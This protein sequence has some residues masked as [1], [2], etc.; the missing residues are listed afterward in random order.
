MTYE[1]DQP[2]YKLL[3]LIFTVLLIAGNQL[4]LR[5]DRF[6]TPTRW[7]L[8][9]ST[10][11]THYIIRKPDADKNPVT[12]N[13]SIKTGKSKIIPSTKSDRELFI[14]SLPPDVVIGMND[15]VSPDMKSAVIVKDNDLFYFLLK[16]IKN[17]GD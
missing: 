9:G 17:S 14:E 6:A 12:M 15:I 4:F 2:V 16:E 7:L 5:K 3:L 11:D 8:L 13:V 10:D 1:K